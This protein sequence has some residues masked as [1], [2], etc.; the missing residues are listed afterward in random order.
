M[1]ADYPPITWD[2]ALQA[3]ARQLLQ[4]AR[5]EDLGELGDV[6]TQAT[7]DPAARGAADVVARQSG[8]VA[9]LGIGQLAIEA[10]AADAEFMPLVD[11][12]TRVEPGQPV[13]RLSGRAAD[14]LTVERT[15]LNFL[16]R[17]SGVATQTARYVEAAGSDSAQVY[18]TRKTTPGWR[19]LEKYAV[20]QGGGRNH[21]LGLHSAVLIKDNHLALS[22]Q[23]GLTPADAVLRARTY[24][25]GSELVASHSAMVVEVEV[26]TLAQ[27]ATVLPAQPDVI[28]LDNMTPQQLAEAVQMR[29]RHAET[30]GQRA[31]LEAS[32]GVRLETIGEIARSAVDRISVGS[33]T[34][35]AVT[36]D[37]GLDWVDQ[38]A[39]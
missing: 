17:L 27:L 37:F 4:L 24:L 5:D 16:G 22:D 13:A 38:T 35:A 39:R 15:L 3:E 33:L 8:V 12:A 36:L 18:D 20:R 23:A 34:H 19:R 11:D 25:S 14:L 2:E 28:L 9:G 6:T 29:N 32:G 21:R 7:V 31:V 26:D 10:F 30:T 1:P